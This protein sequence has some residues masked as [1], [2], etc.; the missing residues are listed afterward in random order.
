MTRTRKKTASPTCIRCG[1]VRKKTGG[2]TSPLCEL[3]RPVMTK[4]EREYWLT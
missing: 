1:F 2:N 3:C 4:K